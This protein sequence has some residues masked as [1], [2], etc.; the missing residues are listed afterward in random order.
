M[1]LINV[2]TLVVWAGSEMGDRIQ[3]EAM[4]SR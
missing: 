4:G 1:V 3:N 2:E